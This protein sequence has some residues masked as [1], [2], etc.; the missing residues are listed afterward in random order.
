MSLKVDL[1]IATIQPTL[2]LVTQLPR[3]GTSD[4]LTIHYLNYLGMI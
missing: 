3:L 1:S 2:D 4:A